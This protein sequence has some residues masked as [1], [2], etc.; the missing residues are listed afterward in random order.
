MKLLDSAQM[1]GEKIE[2]IE[3]RIEEADRLHKKSRETHE[4]YFDTEK[5]RFL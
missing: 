3:D 1:N 4:K 5:Q 2:K